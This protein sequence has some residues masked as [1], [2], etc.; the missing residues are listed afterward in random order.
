MTRSALSTRFTPT[1]TIRRRSRRSCA[2][3]RCGQAMSQALALDQGVHPGHHGLDLLEPAVPAVAVGGGVL[4]LGEPAVDAV[5]QAGTVLQEVFPDDDRVHDREDPGGS[6]E[7]LLGEVPEYQGVGGLD[8]APAFADLAKFYRRQAES[9]G[10]L[11]DVA[12][13]PSRVAGD[14][15]HA[16]AL[17]IGYLRGESAGGELVEGL[18][19]PGTGQDVGDV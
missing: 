4:G 15:D 17:N 7:R 6:G 18:H 8:E 3:C 14:E 13:G 2:T 11:G 12:A 9:F 16:S 10:E 5:C 19:D 1:S